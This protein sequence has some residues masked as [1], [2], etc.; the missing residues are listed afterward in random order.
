MNQAAAIR[1]EVD[2][3]YETERRILLGS[4]GRPVTCFAHV[5]PNEAYFCRILEPRYTTVKDAAM[6][7]EEFSVHVMVSTSR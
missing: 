1:H 4:I 7:F 6:T 5:S 3:L 2:Q